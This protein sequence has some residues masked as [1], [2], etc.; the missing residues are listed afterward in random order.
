MSLFEKKVKL[1]ETK[2]RAAIDH[3]VQVLA[4][5]GIRAH[6]WETEAFPVLGGAHMVAADWAGEKPVMKRDERT[7]WNLEVP[8]KVR[9]KAMK[10]L[11]EDGDA[12]LTFSDNIG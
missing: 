7:V 10:I 1:L 4:E 5:H 2:D 6:I 11:M 9:Y 3:M 12:D 8:K